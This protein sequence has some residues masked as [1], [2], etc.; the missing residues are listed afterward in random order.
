MYKPQAAG[1]GSEREAAVDLDY[2]QLFYRESGTGP[3]L[4]FIHGLLANGGLWS[5]LLPLLS[6]SFRCVMP[7]LPLGSH[8]LPM[9]GD[10]D[11]TPAGIADLIAAFIEKL[12]LREV[13]IVGNDTGGAFCQMMMTQHPD[14][15]AAAVLTNCDCYENFL[16]WSLR[17]LHWGAFFPGF[18]FAVAQLMRPKLVRE[19]V[20][21]A[22]AHCPPPRVVLDSC[23]DPLLRLP[24]VRRDLS[25]VLR[26]ISNRYTLAAARNF[27]NFKKPVLIVWGEDDLFFPMRYAKR[28]ARDFPNARLETIAKSRTFVC[29]DQPQTLAQMIARF[30]R[31]RAAA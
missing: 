20:F 7:D 27:A 4:L 18:T 10:A 8:R 21:A 22:L 31:G 25:K 24:L 13:T 23:L 14:R 29:L 17:A 9:S 15:L 11:L 2:G 19:L 1:K 28:H 6:T 16:P 26:G 30:A 12:D 5:Q 3:A